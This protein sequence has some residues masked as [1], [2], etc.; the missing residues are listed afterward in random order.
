MKLK[1]KKMKFTTKLMLIDNLLYLIFGI[2]VYPLIPYLLN[3]PPYSIDT[4][5]QSIVVGM[6]YTNQF[7]LIFIL[8]LLLNWITLYL[9]FR[10]LNNWRSYIKT[11]TKENKEN[12]LK[13]RNLCSNG[14]Y[15]LIPT[16][17]IV[18]AIVLFIVFTVASTEFGL[19]IKLT[20]IICI[21]TTIADLLLYVFTNK[22]FTK[23]LEETYPPIQ[24]E[25]DTIIRVSIHQ[26]MIIQ[27]ASCILVILFVM[28]LF[29]YSRILY[30][31]GEFL[32]EKEQ[33]ELN[34]LLQENKD[35]ILSVI[36]QKG[37]N[38]FIL[39]EE[40]NSITNGIELSKFAREYILHFEEGNRVYWQYGSSIEGV[41]RK[42]EKNGH[43]YYV[44]KIYDVMPTYYTL[45]FL[46]FDVCLLAIY[47]VIVNCFARNIKYQLDMISE[48]LNKIGEMK[49][50]VGMQLP[51]TSNDEFSDLV[52]AY[53]QVQK[54]TENFVR[55]LNEKQDIIVK[56]GQLVSIGELAG[57]VAHDINTPISAIKTGILM[58][59]QM[60]SAKT[61]D[62]K[63][64]L[65]RMDNCAEKII[66]IVNSMRNQIR[67]LGSDDNIVFKV[68]DVIND[69]KVITYHEVSKNKAEV[70]VE[71]KD[72][73]SISG[74]PTKLG[75][76]LT[77]LVVNGAQ[78]YKQNETGKIMITVSKA[79]DNMALIE[80]TDFA[81]GIDESIAPYIFN[82]ILTT[83]GTS[84]T[85][86]GLY[87][88]YSIIKGNFNG[89]ISYETEKGKGTTFYIYIP[90]A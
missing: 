46:A 82:N 68:S 80:V 52:K 23:I 66:K 71:I 11:D 87:L 24:N 30:E 36:E 89:N 25:K 38:Y 12:I 48:K 88:A 56:Q 84:G 3:Y 7:I 10:K 19:T 59:S 42:V 49:N 21:W 54:N 28:T 35:N 73:L 67:N 26:K 29:G 27:Y 86:L 77:N 53:N 55:E 50:D 85:G 8:G 60:G 2:I 51:L 47:L 20:G 45:F 79:P 64:I 9:F 14:I 22:A 4:E 17:V 69:V 65:Q 31:R 72:D 13:I 15:R 6:Q 41:F 57:G 61:E 33:N 75:Q 70:V 32:R 74:D 43:Y 5:F 62:E 34:T 83:K 76:V 81:G 63:E 16:Q 90:R 78:A 58:L 18:N 40:G 39:D 1:S 44:G 37:D